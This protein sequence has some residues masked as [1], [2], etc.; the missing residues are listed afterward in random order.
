MFQAPLGTTPDITIPC[1]SMLYDDFEVAKKV[2]ASNN[3]SLIG[4]ILLE[5]SL[6]PFI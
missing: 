1:Y 2:S 5:G 6:Y 3:A 4:T